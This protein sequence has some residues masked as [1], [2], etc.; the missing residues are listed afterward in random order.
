MVSTVLG[1]FF[2][3]VALFVIVMIAISILIQATVTQIAFW[4]LRPSEMASMDLVGIV[5]SLGGTTGKITTDYGIYTGA[6]DYYV[7]RTE[8][9][10]CVISQR[11]QTLKTPVV[12]LLTSFNCFTMPFTPQFNLREEIEPTIDEPY[13]LELEKIFQDPFVVVRRS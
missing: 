9:I 3:Y 11:R 10:V 8:K 12:G 1:H 13:E 5:T 4:I 7:K 2:F 6:V